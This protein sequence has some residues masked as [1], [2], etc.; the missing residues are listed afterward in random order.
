[1]FTQLGF[2]VVVEERAGE[3]AGFTDAQYQMAGAMVASTADVWGSVDVIVKLRE[4][5]MHP[6]L[7]IHEVFT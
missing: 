7:G 1:V 4:P 5:M 6:V 2:Q 3:A